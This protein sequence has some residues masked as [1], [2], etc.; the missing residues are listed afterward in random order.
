MKKWNV[1]P[2]SAATAED[3][4]MRLAG[5][6]NHASTND[7][8]GFSK[9]DAEFGHSLAARAVANHAWTIRQAEAALVL[10]K[11]YRRQLGDTTNIEEWL[12]S[13]VFRNEPY[14]QDSKNTGKPKRILKKNGHNAVFEFGYDATLIKEL[15]TRLAGEIGGKRYRPSWNPTSKTWEIPLNN[16]SIPQIMQFAAE[17]G[18]SVM[19]DLQ[20]YL[21]SFQ[22]NL[23]ED[24][25]MLA[26]NDNRHIVLASD[27]IIIIVDNPA[28]MEEF[29]H[30]L[31]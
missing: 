3:M 16:A 19:D 20:N 9:I 17:F 7:G 21:D 29:Q 26:L 23:T 4:V 12:K 11:K 13:P 2:A 5:V 28:I 30:V 6:C 18:F 10:I 31:G 15:K 22:E 25:F 14:Q 8:A 27:K 1:D 24:R